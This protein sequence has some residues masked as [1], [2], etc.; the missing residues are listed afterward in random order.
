MTRQQKHIDYNKRRQAENHGPP[1]YIQGEGTMIASPGALVG[2]RGGYFGF[3]Y[4]LEDI[5]MLLKPTHASEKHTK[6]LVHCPKCG[7]PSLILRKAIML[8]NR[9]FAGEKQLDFRGDERRN[10]ETHVENDRTV[11]AICLSCEHNR[12]PGTIIST[13]K[14]YSWKFADRDKIL[15]YKCSKCRFSC[16]SLHDKKSGEKV[17]IPDGEPIPVSQLQHLQLHCLCCGNKRNFDMKS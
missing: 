3:R 2:G 17:E 5:Q 12:T 11:I 8:Y 1:L 9:V 7:K 16:L 15:P 10:F 13:E 6:N 14:I 4:S